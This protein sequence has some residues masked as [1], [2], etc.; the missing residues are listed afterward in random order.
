[1]V[2]GVPAALVGIVFVLTV[3]QQRKIHHPQY[4]V[5][6]GGTQAQAVA[7]FQAQFAELLAGLVGLARNQQQQVAGLRV[8]SSGPLS[9]TGFVVKFIDGGF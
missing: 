5:L 1:M 3:F 9:Q 2:H 7:H 4:A 8:E 6:V